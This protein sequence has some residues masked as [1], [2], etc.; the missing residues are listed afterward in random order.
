MMLDPTSEGA[1]VAEG[2]MGGTGFLT[3]YRE[4]PDPDLLSG[5][6]DMRCKNGDSG[7][8]GMG[9]IGERTPVA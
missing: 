7:E 1:G 8:R 9:A 2:S 3:V 5:C 4:R 6:I